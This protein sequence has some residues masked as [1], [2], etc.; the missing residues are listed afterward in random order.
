MLGRTV[1]GTG[2]PTTLQHCL[3][4]EIQA[5]TNCLKYSKEG[6]KRFYHRKEVMASLLP[7]TGH[8]EGDGEARTNV[9]ATTSS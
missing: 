9:R 4:K 3:G 5:P 2:L 6:H 8:Q 7:N 1:G